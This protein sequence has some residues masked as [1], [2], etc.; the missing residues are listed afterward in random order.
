MRALKV[1][2]AVIMAGCASAPAGPAPQPV[3]VTRNRDAL[4][5]CTALGVVD[6]SDNVGS[7]GPSDRRIGE[8]DTARQLRAAA[9]RLGANTLLLTDN[10]GGMSSESPQ[11]ARGEAFKC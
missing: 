3:S 10:F 9:A 6:A 2:L 4:K 8:T 5:G 11:F 1:V 7:G